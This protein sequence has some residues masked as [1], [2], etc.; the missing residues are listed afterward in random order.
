MK[1]TILTPSYNRGHTLPKLYESLLTQTSSNFEWLV[2]DDGSKD[3]TE[4]LIKKYI[5]EK[6]IDVRYIKKENGGKHTAVNEG[7]A[8][9]S[10]EMTF[11]VDSD[12]YLSSDAVETI[13]LYFNKYKDVK[14]VCGFSFLRSTIKENKTIGEEYGQN[15]FIDNYI[16]Y[17]VNKNIKG[18]KAEVYYTSV[19]KQYPFPVYNGERFLSE[20][21][22]WIE[23]AKKYDTLYIN[24]AIYYCEYLEDGLTTNDKKTKFKSPLGSM[25]RGKQMMY[26]KLN[27]KTRIKGAII[28]NCYKQEIK[29][30]VPESLRLTKKKDRILVLLTKVLGKIYNKKWKKSIK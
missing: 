29:Q 14:K 13:E 17:R 8:N 7:V 16:S 28:Y 25:H 22:V 27:F 21:V 6:K 18:D 15:E 19:L 12:D 10:S 30:S 23:M 3:E 4:I 24:K 20:D 1:V 11:I 9:I 2:V 5:E 26:K